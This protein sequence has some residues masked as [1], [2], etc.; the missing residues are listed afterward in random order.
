MLD[1][2]KISK[3]FGEKTILAE[4]NLTI[5]DGEFF[6]LLGPSGCGKT[7][8]LRIIAG[9]ETSTAG[10]ILLNG[11]SIE[12]IPAQERPFNMVFQRYALFPHMTVEENLNFGLDVKKISSAEKKSRINETLELVGLM[13][14][15]TKYPETLSGGQAQ[16]VALARAL[17]NRPK[18]LLLDEPL[19]ALDLKMREHMQRELR[20]LQKKLGM[21]FIY[22]THDQDEALVM[23]DRI[24]VMNNGRLEQVSTPRELYEKPQTSF[25]AEFVGNMNKFCGE[26]IEVNLGEWSFSLVGGQQMKGLKNQHLPDLVPGNQIHAYI[27]PEKV[28]VYKMQLKESENNIVSGTIKHFIFKGNQL[29]SYVETRSCGMIKIVSPNQLDPLFEIGEE[30]YL[31]LPSEHLHLFKQY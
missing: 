7:T 21:T 30:V 11:N 29:E 25:S 8:L 12:G 19:S 13:E 2:K 9:L 10:T 22:V 26:I 15:K 27:R 1:I 4:L 28:E 16:R 20:L 5:H 14:F 17:V 18:I 24:G 6:S 31:K 23:S 3:K